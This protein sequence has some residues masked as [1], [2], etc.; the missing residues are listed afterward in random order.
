MEAF[1]YPSD[2]EISEVGLR[3]LFIGNYDI[4]DANAH[5]E[6]VKARY[7]WKES[8]VPFERTYRRFSNLDDRHENGAHDYLKYIKF[9]YGRATDHACKDI[10]TG[11]LSREEG[12][13]RVKQYDHVRP[14][15]LDFWLE[16]VKKDESWFWAIADRFRVRRFGQKTIKTHG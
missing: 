5:T 10:R 7:G 13:E 11:Y 14:S 1:K 15:D 12:I 4:W 9:G 3:G 2:R 8:P 6:L 16:Y